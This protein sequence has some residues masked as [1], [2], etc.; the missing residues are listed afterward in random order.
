MQ[1]HKDSLTFP[2]CKDDTCLGGI[3]GE[4]EQMLNQLLRAEHVIP[5]KYKDSLAWGLHLSKSSHLQNIF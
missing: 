3:S 5:V 1:C 2:Y 4:G